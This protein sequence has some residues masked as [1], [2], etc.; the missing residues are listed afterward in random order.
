MRVKAVDGIAIVRPL[1]DR[2]P[3]RVIDAAERL[4]RGGLLSERGKIELLAEYADLRTAILLNRDCGGPVSHV[5]DAL[6]RMRRNDPAANASFVQWA[7]GVIAPLLAASLVIPHPSNMLL[8]RAFSLLPETYSSTVLSRIT[9]EPTAAQT[10]YLLV[11]WLYAG[12]FVRR[13]C[14]QRRSLAFRK[15]CAQ[16]QD[17][18]CCSSMA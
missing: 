5:A 10:H 11:A 17:E 6:A 15:C 14:T 2:A 1:V 16:P 8:R 9:S 7:A 12:F 13:D 18:L 4:L 3:A